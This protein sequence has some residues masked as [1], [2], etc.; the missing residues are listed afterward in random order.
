MFASLNFSSVCK[1]KIF[2]LEDVV[3]TGPDL[4]PAKK[5]TVQVDNGWIGK[6]K[7]VSLNISLKVNEQLNNVFMLND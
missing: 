2:E 4:S 7:N 3:E 5:S 6:K 1:L